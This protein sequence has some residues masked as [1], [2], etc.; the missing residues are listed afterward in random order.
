MTEKCTTWHHVFDK[1]VKKK[2]KK[3]FGTETFYDHKMSK[4]IYTQKQL[5]LHIL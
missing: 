2:K 4:S 5:Q 1:V 3:G